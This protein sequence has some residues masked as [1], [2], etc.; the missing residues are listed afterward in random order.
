[1]VAAAQRALV[2]LGF[3][4]EADGVAG[5]S[6]RQAIE[7]Y[8]RDRGLPARGVLSPDLVRRLGT[9]SGMPIN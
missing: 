6:T 1:M 2:K 9:E 4:L 8:E 3:V 7:R 5:T